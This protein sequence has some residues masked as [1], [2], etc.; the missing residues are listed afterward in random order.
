MKKLLGILL[1]LAAL[2]AMGQTKFRLF[3]QVVAKGSGVTPA[4]GDIFYVSGSGTTGTIS[5]LGIGSLGDCLSVSGA[6]VPFWT[7]T[8][9]SGG[10]ITFAAPSQYTVTGS[11]TSSISFAWNSVSQNY[12][13]MGPTS[14]AGQPSFRGIT[15]GDLPSSWNDVFV[16][17]VGHKI[18]LVPDP[19]A[20]PGTTR[21]LREDATWSSTGSGTVTSVALSTPS[22]FTVSGSPVTNTGTLNFSL[23]SQTQRLFFA[24]P[25]S[26]TGAPTFRA[27][28]PSDLGM[29]TK[30][31][32]VTK[33]TSSTAL[34]SVPV[35]ADGTILS[36]DSASSG[37]L[38]WIA[39][40]GTGTVT[41]VALTAPSIFTVTGSPVTTT[42]T[43]D[44]ALNTQA[45]HYAFMGG[46]ILGPHVPTFRA[47]DPTDLPVA[48]ATVAGIV[49]TPPNDNTKVLLGN[50][51]W[52]TIAGVGTVT[53]VA[54]TVPAGFAIGGSPVTSSGTLAITYATGQ[55]ANRFLATPDGSTGA[56][57]LRG[58]ARGDLT[59]AIFVASG[60]THA[61]GAV[62]DPGVS[63]GSTN[64]LRED[65]TW[66]L[67]PQ[68]TVTSVDASVP[69]YMTIA[70]NPI[71][72]SGT[73]SFGFGNENANM[74]FAGPATGAAASP[75]WRAL[76]PADY[77]VFIASGATHA[78]GAV[79]DPGVTG[80]TTKFL[81]EDASWQTPTFSSSIEVKE[82]DG[83]PDV[84]GVSVLRFNQ[85]DGLTVTDNTGGIA[86][87]S[88]STCGAIGAISA[89][90]DE[91]VGNSSAT[92]FTLSA[93]P[94]TNG[95]VYVSLNGL[96][97]ITS[98]WTLSG[99]NILMGV[100]PITGATLSVGYF[101][102]LPG[103]ISHMQEDFTGDAV[104]MGFSLAHTPA[105]GGVLVVAVGGLVQPQTSW[106]LVGG[107]V[108]TMTTAP[109]NGATLSCSYNY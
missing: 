63:A 93:T 37:G 96:P 23:N 6:G 92:S 50:A 29:T 7:N 67:P 59:G 102:A 103:A 52:G 69:S 64:F 26:S 1:L 106:S 61:A 18:G 108:L 34:Y 48:T 84:V 68:G 49:P 78:A 33:D 80:G 91:F 95:I 9:G 60:A 11:G 57:S 70:G 76:V 40:S 89:K 45:N 39:L 8:C 31:D 77:P 16:E 12:A 22:I 13:L 51:T 54:Q 99:S 38:K 24:S 100:A 47:I 73:L 10:T 97:Q 75:T 28:S 53:S 81:R 88:C 27:I 43:I 42:G 72:S 86:T 4:K 82:V 83:T 32:L 98:S 104:T 17:G 25:I 55:T 90:Q 5:K 20:T 41:S 85:A 30:G 35:G 79:P 46:I 21:F 62:P 71:S 58:I 107:N 3:D 87:V 105:T 36:A 101:T 56:L 2:P 74:I 15:I 94:S 19:G 66:A 109:A 44:F 65:A 14:G